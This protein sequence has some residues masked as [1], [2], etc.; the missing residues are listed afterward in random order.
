MVVIHQSSCIDCGER[1]A[2]RGERDLATWGE[3]NL[4][5]GESARRERGLIAR[6]ESGLIARKERGLIAQ[7]KRCIAAR[8]ERCLVAR[9]STASQRERC[10]DCL[11][12][13]R[14]HSIVI[15]CEPSESAISEILTQLKN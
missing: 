9:E 10:L 7:R 2:A 1:L 12:F 13:L 11:D 3:H 14:P 15:H 5:R 4:P 6:R 8:G